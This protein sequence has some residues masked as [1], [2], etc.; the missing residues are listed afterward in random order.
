MY[1]CMLIFKQGHMH[2]HQQACM[3]VCTMHT[4]KH[5]LIHVR[6]CEHLSPPADSKYYH[7][8]KEILL[9]RMM[10]IFYSANAPVSFN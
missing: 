10:F 7:I 9:H 5:A 6:A 3:S 1:T 2:A 8:F 4:F